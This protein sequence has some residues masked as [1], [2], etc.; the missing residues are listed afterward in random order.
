MMQPRVYLNPTL[1]IH[2][3]DKCQLIRANWN[4]GDDSDVMEC[5]IVTPLADVWM[6]D[7]HISS[8]TIAT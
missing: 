3:E 1:K 2:F 7:P 4:P 6:R 5:R 8:S